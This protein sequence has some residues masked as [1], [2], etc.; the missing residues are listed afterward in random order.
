M[1]WRLRLS[2]WGQALVLSKT[3][4]NWQVGI[5][6]GAHAGALRGEGP[7]LSG[8]NEMEAAMKRAPL[9]AATLAVLT[10][11]PLA[12]AEEIYMTPAEKAAPTIE[13]YIDHTDP[14][15]Y[16]TAWLYVKV[17]DP[18]TGALYAIRIAT[19]I[20]VNK[21]TGAK[22]KVS[23]PESRGLEWPREAPRAPGAAS[24]K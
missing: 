7:C 19:E 23:R 13:G 9:V 6:R 21:K 4:H 17:R 12:L 15:P 18:E 16:S 1:R 2:H 24:L 10:S 14:G 8:I 11:I 20:V 5:L 22:T 3:P